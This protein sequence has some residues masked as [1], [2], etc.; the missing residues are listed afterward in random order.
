M[1]MTTT[2]GSDRQWR[3]SWLRDVGLK[4]R[5]VLLL[6]LVGLLASG[7]PRK[8]DAQ[9]SVSAQTPQAI[10]PRIKATG[11]QTINVPARP[12]QPPATVAIIKDSSLNYSS[13]VSQALEAALG[14]GGIANL[15]H[16]GDTVLIKPNLVTNSANAVTDWHVVKALVDLIKAVN[17]GASITIAD[18][19]ATQDTINSV[20]VNQGYTTA[21]FPGVIFANFNDNTT[22]PTN[23][24]VLADSRTGASE[25][26]PALITE[27][28]RSTSIC[29]R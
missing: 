6:P 27:R 25:Q 22:N 17:G 18:G 24:Y 1:S 20:M 21:N 23:T 26:I 9:D 4:P 11:G 2:E 5:A 28:R 3:S 7:C 19:S 29:P 16:S 15:V 12:P 8:W 13:M 14:S 10:Q